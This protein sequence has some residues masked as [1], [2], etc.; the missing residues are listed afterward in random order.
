MLGNP[1]C[2]DTQ[3]AGTCPNPALC[4]PLHTLEEEMRKLYCLQ[5]PSPHH[6][7]AHPPAAVP[8]WGTAEAAAQHTRNSSHLK[9]WMCLPLCVY[10]CRHK[11]MHCTR[12]HTPM[13]GCAPTPSPHHTNSLCAQA[14]DRGSQQPAHEPAQD[15][16]G[17]PSTPLQCMQRMVC[18]RGQ[19]TGDNYCMQ[20]WEQQCCMKSTSQPSMSRPQGQLTLHVQEPQQAVCCARTGWCRLC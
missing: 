9:R 18:K 19:Q 14:V 1:A 8:A 16:V 11:A 5:P 2:T 7:L 20:Q 13:S 15:P 10:A 12:P 3:A 17:L 4:V 6:E